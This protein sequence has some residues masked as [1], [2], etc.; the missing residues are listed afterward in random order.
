MKKNKTGIVISDSMNKTRVVEVEWT[1]R[2]PLYEKVI[3]KSSKFYAHD[4]K[5]ESHVGDKVKIVE[6]RPISK[7]KRWNIVKSDGK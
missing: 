3:R 1:M 4:E 6:V 5:N 2:H 7:N